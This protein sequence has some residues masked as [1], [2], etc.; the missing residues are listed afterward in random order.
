MTIK[1]CSRIAQSITVFLL[2]LIFY[3][4]TDAP[5]VIIFCEQLYLIKSSSVQCI[6]CRWHQLVSVWEQFLMLFSHVENLNITSNSTKDLTSLCKCYFFCYL[7][8]SYIIVLFLLNFICW[9]NLPKIFTQSNNSTCLVCSIFLLI[10]ASILSPD[11][12]L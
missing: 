2:S 12:K 4:A 7:F 6:L 8:S 3:F 11:Q 5:G 9:G 1:K 10:S